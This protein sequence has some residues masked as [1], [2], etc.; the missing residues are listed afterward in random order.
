MP[1][2]VKVLLS[3]FAVLAI[4]LVATYAFRD[5][6]ATAAFAYG[7]DHRDGVACSHPRIRIAS[8]LDEVEIA[9]LECALSRGPLAKAKTFTPARIFLDG[10]RVKRVSIARAALD[11]RDRDLARVESNTL[12]DVVDLAGVRAPMIN[13]ILDASEMYSPDAPPV[14]IDHLTM[15]RNG[16]TENVL[17]DYSR[18]IEGEW[19]RSHARRV[20][21][22]IEGIASARNLDMRVTPLRGK[23]TVALYLGDKER[24]EEPDVEMRIAAKQLDQQSPKFEFSMDTDESPSARR[25]RQVEEAQTAKARMTKRP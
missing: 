23:V 3:V 21:T 8:S 6:I 7:V 10:S 16:E 18:R 24:G 11:F 4:L 2:W 25:T 13:S 1:R 22:G 9:P 5:P 20:E 14:S 19:S 12:G 15:L 17:H